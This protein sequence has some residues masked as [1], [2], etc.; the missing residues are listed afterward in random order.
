MLCFLCRKV[1]IKST[2][3]EWSLQHHLTFGDLTEAADGGCELCRLFR[4]TIL[5]YYAE[6]HGVSLDAAEDFHLELD[7]DGVGEAEADRQVF[8]VQLKTIDI[9]E[10]FGPCATGAYGLIYVR[11]PPGDDYMPVGDV[12][13]FVEFS[14]EPGMT[15]R[16]I[17]LVT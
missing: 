17:Y 13:P 14:V 9:D 7:D 5:H 12:Y 11:H 16:N 15:S 4:A 6:K 3:S 8:Y 1:Q 10:R 2:V